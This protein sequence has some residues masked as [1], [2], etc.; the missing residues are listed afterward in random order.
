MAYEPQ[1]DLTRELENQAAV[2]A[3][4]AAV[5]AQ[6]DYPPQPG[7][8]P[9]P[10]PAY[11]RARHPYPFGPPHRQAPDSP[12]SNSQQLLVL[13][14]FYA[15]NPNPSKRELEMLAERTGRPWN[16]IREYFRQRR[17]KLRGL[18]DLEAM[19]E[20][21]RAS[22]WLQ[23]TYRAG[24]PTASVSQLAVYNAYKTRFDPYTTS[25]PL[26][27][28]QELIQLA[29]ST[30]PGCEMARDEGDYVLRGLRDKDGEVVEAEWDRGVDAM[31]EPLRGTTWLLSNY[32]H[33]G[34]GG[35]PSPTQAELYTAYA[36]R[37]SSIASEN[38]EEQTADQSVD[39]S[40]EQ[41]VDQSGV[42][43]AELDAAEHADLKDF[44]TNMGMEG[45]MFLPQDAEHQHEQHQSH[46]HSQSEQQQQEQHGQEGQDQGDGHEPQP[47][48][49]PPTR[50]LNPVE[51]IALTR[52]TF[53]KCEPAVDED[54]RF[55]I[56]GLERREGVEKGRVIKTADMF[57]FALANAP[58]PSDPAH[59]FTSLLKRKL[60]LLNPE[61]DEP[62]KRRSGIGVNIAVDAEPELTDEDRELLDGL[63]RFRHSKLG[64]EVRDT[65]V[66]Q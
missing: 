56:R 58:A 57:P 23:V 42:D 65:C 10:P 64:R 48:H 15:R 17:N 14:E 4:A 3:V 18:S 40:V 22:S 21:G 45:D 2:E 36:A 60:A 29:C 59:P 61:P 49:R 38:N 62:S 8:G 31:V 44:E 30:F 5:A 37:F 12:L 11:A 27:G 54:G 51:L 28:G 6:D 13:R 41:S 47:E 34:E 1:M 19:E 46:E 55:V 43:L 9:P 7:H 25:A 32:Q 33:Q 52:M 35:G 16:K 53:P 24:P 20:P 50:M 66:Q 63:R 39:H 26:L